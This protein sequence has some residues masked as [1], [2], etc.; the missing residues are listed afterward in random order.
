MLLLV[1]ALT[2]QNWAHLM[3]VQKRGKLKLCLKKVR[4]KIQNI[5]KKGKITIVVQSRGKKTIITYILHIQNGDVQ[6]R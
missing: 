4:A 5:K 3:A 6:E 2:H 1:A